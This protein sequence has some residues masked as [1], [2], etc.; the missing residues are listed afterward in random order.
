MKSLTRLLSVI[1]KASV[2]E[3]IA[4]LTD[5][6]ASDLLFRLQVQADMHYCDA[7]DDE[8]RIRK[9]EGLNSLLKILEEA[10]V[11]RD[12]DALFVYDDFP[13]FHNWAL[14]FAIKD[15]R[16]ALGVSKLHGVITQRHLD[17]HRKALVGFYKKGGHDPGNQTHS[18]AFHR[19]NMFLFNE[20]F[21]QAET[22][23]E[24][25][26]ERKVYS[27]PELCALM[28]VSTE[29]AAPLASGAL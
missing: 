22:I 1:R 2:Q 29:L 19:L 5:H 23:V 10:K 3:S 15:L 12:F 20:R 9:P 14:E 4:S 8:R 11:N 17:V 21:H 28:D 25:M 24:I 16:K 18:H 6:E 13:I 27:V 7:T 26:T